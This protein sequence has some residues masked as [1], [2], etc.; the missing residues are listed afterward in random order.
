MPRRAAAVG[1]H[2]RGLRRATSSGSARCSTPAGRRGV[3]ARGVRRP[4]REPVGVADLRGGVLP[5]PARRSG[6]RRT[7]SSCS[8]RRSSSSARR[9]SRTAS[10]RRWPR[11]S[12]PWCQGWSRARTP[13]SDL[14]GIQSRAVRDDAA[15]GWRLTGQ[16]TWTTRG[17]FC[18]HLFGLFRTDPDAERHHGLT[19]FLVAAR[20]RPA[21]RCA[22][23]SGSTAT[24][25]SPRCSST[26]CS[27]PTPT[28]SASVERGLGRRDG[29]DRL[30]ARAHAALAR[31]ASSPTARPARSTSYRARGDRRDPRCA[32]G[33]V[34]GVDRRRGLPLA[35]ASGPSPRIVDGRSHRAPSRAST[36]VFWSELDVAPA[37][38][39]AR[40]ARPARGAAR[41]RRR[42]V[43]EGLRVRARRARSTPAPTR[44]S[45]TSIAERVLGLPRK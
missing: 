2:P 8:R 41:R 3:V 13:G 28:C 1:R 29:D 7:A 6:S 34:A 27:S 40:P 35:D 44:S 26:T 30:R 43:D 21:S 22:A 23:S 10:C 37:R 31:A 38:D 9:S 16:K 20:R 18:T 36:K 25:A 14:A 5:R 15:G 32:T 4:R 39:R 11:A 33:V 24:R 12:R 19:Y 42:G 45:A 17:A